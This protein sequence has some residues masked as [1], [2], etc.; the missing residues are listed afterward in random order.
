MKNII[1]MTEQTLDLVR[2]DF[3]GVESISY[4]LCGLSQG[5]ERRFLVR[6]M[7]VPRETDYV[8][9]QQCCAKTRG[10]F[11]FS[12]YE[13]CQKEKLNAVRSTANQRLDPWRQAANR[14]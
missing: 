13:R 2:H 1:V 8:T 5:A 11:V 12:L 3:R 14:L 10:E 7:V 4:A 9:R 6:S